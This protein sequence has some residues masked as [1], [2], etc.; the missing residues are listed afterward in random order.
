M[1]QSTKDKLFMTGLED[2]ESTRGYFYC[3]Y[4]ICSVIVFGVAAINGLIYGEYK[5]LEML[6]EI[7]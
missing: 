2:E 5:V 7:F 1:K 4:Q 3:M 6:S